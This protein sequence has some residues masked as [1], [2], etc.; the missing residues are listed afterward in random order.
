V[1]LAG[2]VTAVTTR[3]PAH[4]PNRTPT[5]DHK[6]LRGTA[7]PGSKTGTKA[8]ENRVAR[9]CSQQRIWSVFSKKR[10][11]SR[12]AGPPVHDDLVARRFTAAGPDRGQ[13]RVTAGNA[14]G[15]ADARE[16]PRPARQA[17]PTVRPAYATTLSHLA[18]DVWAQVAAVRPAHAYGLNGMFTRSPEADWV[19]NRLFVGRLKYKKCQHSTNKHGRVLRPPRSGRA[20]GRHGVG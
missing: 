10:G 11:L 13:C 12:K 18:D 6:P 14:A 16:V 20:E 7:L 17:F 3:S 19:A 4:P 2:L 15:Q 8:G 5:Q 1:R 9:L